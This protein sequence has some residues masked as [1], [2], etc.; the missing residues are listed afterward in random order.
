MLITDNNY[1][2]NINKSIIVL[3]NTKDDKKVLDK[4]IFARTEK[5]QK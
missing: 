3:Y 4:I 1:N 2:R 5:K